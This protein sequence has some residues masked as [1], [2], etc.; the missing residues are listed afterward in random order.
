MVLGG[1]LQCQTAA[2]IACQTHVQARFLEDMVSKLGGR[3]FAVATG[4]AHH[5]GI[6]V[7]TCKLDFAHDGNA[8]LDGLGHHG[9][10]VG[11]AG[12][13]HD[14]VG[15]E[16]FLGGVSTLFPSDVILVEQVL[17]GLPDV[18][19]VAQPHVHALYLGEHRSSRSALTAA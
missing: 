3:G 9:S 5:L 4:D 16:D 11:N 15:I 19:G 10:R 2:H 18:A 6:G 7:T 1:H 12:A 13:L 17:V 14:L 8:L